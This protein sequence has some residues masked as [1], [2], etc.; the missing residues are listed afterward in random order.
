[1]RNIYVQLP[2][3]AVERLRELARREF[4]D[5]KAQA[6]VLILDGLDREGQGVDLQTSGSSAGAA[7]TRRSTDKSKVEP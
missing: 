3:E 6:A 7:R 1:M 2:S 5:P 4:R